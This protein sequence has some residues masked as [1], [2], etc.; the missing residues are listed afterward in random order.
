MIKM[1]ITSDLDAIKLRNQPIAKEGVLVYDD[2][3]KAKLWEH[4]KRNIGRTRPILNEHPNFDNGFKGLFSGKEKVWGKAIISQC[5]KG[6]KRLCA[7]LVLQ[8]GAPVKK[9][10]SI[11]YPFREIL[12]KGKIGEDEY[13]SVQ[14]HLLIDHIALTNHPRDNTALLVAGDSNLAII[15]DEVMSSNGDSNGAIVI[16]R[17]GYDSL[18]LELDS[19][20]DEIMEF[21]RRDNSDTT[22]SELLKRAILM[23]QNEKQIN[24]DTENMP[25]G[26]KVEEDQKDEEMEEEEMKKKKKKEASADSL[27]KEEL[28]AE[29]ATLRADR[30][31]KLIFEKKLKSAQSRAEK[32]EADR[33]SYKER[34]EKELTSK[35]QTQVDSLVNDHGYGAKDFTDRSADFVAGAYFVAETISKGPQT[36]ERVGDSE[37]E[38]AEHGINDYVYDHDSKKMVL[39]PEFIKEK[40]GNK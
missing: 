39:K 22:D 18:E 36:G 29:L 33:D 31:A 19:R 1:G 37:Y 26:K 40:E 7:D 3:R 4:L 38:E 17:V 35:V 20:I 6:E 15:D 12:E 32:A 16:N 8:D 11:G 2:G 25:G 5:P 24:G 13:D 23:L 30:D 10:Y 28:F 34:Y 21:L 14:G 27:S 9:G